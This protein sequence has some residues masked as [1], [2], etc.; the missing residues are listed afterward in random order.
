MKDYL[1]MYKENGREQWDRIE[2]AANEAEAVKIL[3]ECE[4]V[5]PLGAL[6]ILSVVECGANQEP[7]KTAEDWNQESARVEAATLAALGAVVATEDEKPLTGNAF[8]NGSDAPE[9]QPEPEEATEDA[10]PVYLEERWPESNRIPGIWYRLTWTK[11]GENY[12]HYTHANT[13]E[14]VRYHAHQIN[15]N[16]GHITQAIRHDE[17]TGK[18]IE[19]VPETSQ[20]KT[21]R[22][23]RATCKSIARAVELYAYG[24]AW[25]CPHCG[26]INPLDDIYEEDRENEYMCPD[27][28]EVIDRDELENLTL[29]DYFSDCLDVEYRCGS[30]REYRSACIMIACGGPNI[31]IDTATKNVELYWWTDRATYPLSY[32]AAEAVD[33]WAREY[34]ECV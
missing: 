29:Y 31:Y 5:L 26:E 25:K 17:N 23:N 19:F 8:L 33:D 10:A 6:E 3:H 15:H 11:P 28:G 12:W 7:E 16:C 30:D 18:T 20:E 32:D 9:A 22:E 27:C 14:E 2:N 13:M 4:P 21:D 1:I 24:N 34:W